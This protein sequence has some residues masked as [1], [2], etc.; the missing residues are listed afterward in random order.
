MS[1]LVDRPPAVSLHFQSRGSAISRKR[2]EVVQWMSDNTNVLPHTRQEETVS[3]QR[4]RREGA[5][6]A[7]N[8][9]SLT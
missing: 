9:A 5:T 4:R 8:L 1:A 7:V 3:H 2:R 6:L